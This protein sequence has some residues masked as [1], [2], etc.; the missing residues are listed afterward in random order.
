[1]VDVRQKVELLAVKLDQLLSKLNQ[2]EYFTA[3]QQGSMDKRSGTSSSITK[4]QNI[5]SSELAEVLQKLEL[6]SDKVDMISDT[7]LQRGLYDPE[8]VKNRINK[9]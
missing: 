1:M 8:E 6:L 2:T 4:D 7:L 9:K 5:T 3:Q